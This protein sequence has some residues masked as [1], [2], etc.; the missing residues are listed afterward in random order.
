[1]E[2]K[3]K[4]FKKVDNTFSQF[5]EEVAQ[6]PQ[7]RFISDIATIQKEIEA[8]NQEKTELKNV[9]E[10]L[11]VM[12]VSELAGEN[13]RKPMPTLADVKA[14]SRQAQPKGEVALDTPAVIE[15]V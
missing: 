2:T 10:S 14:N 6:K 8:E 13:Y 12:R 9:P 3:A 7:N 15:R 4:F 5:I 1:M 11:Q